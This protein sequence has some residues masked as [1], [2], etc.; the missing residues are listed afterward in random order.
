MLAA[1]VIRLPGSESVD[2]A[3][4][5]VDEYQPVAA[6]LGLWEIEPGNVVATSVYAVLY[7]VKYHALGVM[8]PDVSAVDLATQFLQDPAGFSTAARYAS[9]LAGV[10]AVLL[11]WILAA[12]LFDHVTALAVAFLLAIHPLPVGMSG[13]D[14]SESFSIVLLLMALIVAS[15]VTR[16]N[17]RYLDLV[18]IGLCLG[19]AADAVPVLVLSVAITGMAVFQRLPAIRRPGATSIGIG[20]GCFAAATFLPAQG[21]PAV[22]TLFPALP[23]AILIAVVALSGYQ[24]LR[25]A[26]RAFP[27]P[28]YS[29]AVLLVALLLGTSTLGEHAPQRE[30]ENA[31]PGVL[32]SQ[33]LIEHLPADSV[34]V[35]DPAISGE[36]RIPRNARSWR[37]ELRSER[38]TAYPRAYAVAAARAA[39][40]PSE[41]AWDVVIAE[42]PGEEGLFELSEDS[43]TS[44]PLFLILPDSVPRPRYDGDDCWLVARFRSEDPA[45]SGV[46]IWGA[47]GT[48]CSAEPVQVRWHVRNANRLAAAPT[49]IVPCRCAFGCG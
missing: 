28:A 4:L 45:T 23:P 24:V 20:F 32:A 1:L 43:W 39:S 6:A 27:A 13:M 31:A 35:V 9:V 16:R 19:F 40:N 11:G 37:R 8:S 33:W 15:E 49:G 36:L 42:H 18:A 44:T 2:G 17:L 10:A 14:V 29:C 25:L 26:H 3:I 12:R 41:P 7:A 21:T 47:R 34:I 22:S 46:V 48:G 38:P 30:A 5:P